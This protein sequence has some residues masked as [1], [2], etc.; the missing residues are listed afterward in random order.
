MAGPLAR[1]DL[2][3]KITSFVD[4]TPTG[5]VGMVLEGEAGI[6]KTTLWE[7]G[8]ARARESNAQ[9][10]VARVAQAEST[11]AFTALG[12]LF[13]GLPT[14]YFEGL[15]TPQREALEIALLYREASEAAHDPRGVG[16][17]CLAVL[18][19]AQLEAPVL[20]AIDD[21]Q[22]LDPSS[23]YTLSFVLHRLRDE[24]VRLLATRRDGQPM[25]AA[26]DLERTMAPGQLHR[27]QVGPLPPVGISAML[28]DRL[29][30]AF[31]Q[32]LGLR[33]HAASGGNPFFA[34]QIAHEILREGAP[35]PGDALPL[36]DDAFTLVRQRVESLPPEAQTVLR[37]CAAASRPSLELVRRA[38]GSSGRAVDVEASLLLCEQAGLLRVRPMRIGF[39]HPLFASGVL[40]A[41]PAE[42]ARAIHLGLAQVVEEPEQR[43]RHLAASSSCPDGEAAAALEEASQ[44]ARGR[45]AAAVAAELALMAM[46]YTPRAQRPEWLRRRVRSAMY[47]FEAGNAPE[48][49][50]VLDGA[51]GDADHGQDRAMLMLLA[52]EISWQDTRRVEDLARAALDEEHADAWVGAGAH[53]M[54][55]WV[56]VYRGDRAAA[57]HHSAA[58]LAAMGDDPDPAVRSDVLTVGALVDFLDG[59]PFEE[60]LAEAV[61]LQE[62]AET[63][64]ATAAV[65]YSPARVVRGLIALWANR[66]AEA[67]QLLG[68]ELQDYEARGRYVARDE[69]LC[70]LANL[71]CRRGEW[72]KAEIYAEECLD[73]GEESGHLRGRGQNI[74]PRAWVAALRGDVTQARSRAEEGLALS[75]ANQDHL[76]TAMNRGV[77][78]F[79]ALSEGDPSTAVGHLLPMV[80]F[81]KDAGWAEPGMLPFVADA[82]EAL[83]LTARADE[84]ASIVADER[85]MGR[86]R[87]A[88]G[89]LA[90]RRR[91]QG[92]LAASA[93]DLAAALP[94]FAEAVAAGHPQPFEH[95]RAVLLK[96]EAE[97]R[98]KRK[99]RARQDL[100]HA[101][102]LFDELGAVVWAERARTELARV[103]GSAAGGDLSPT[104]WRIAELVAGGKTNREVASLLFLS[105][106]TVEANLSRIY[107][108]LGV[109]S[110]SDLVR[111]LLS[112][113]APEP[114]SVVVPLR[115][116]GDTKSGDASGRRGTS[117]G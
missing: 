115:A 1:G 57:T 80:G 51:I 45:G 93:G 72:D 10:A 105:T 35:R 113:P 97:R 29:G 63:V 116:R 74:A 18:R 82:V 76:A 15:P 39:T 60:R 117:K 2:L 69:L 22:W 54:L 79:I 26:L 8:V 14:R 30:E 33:V 98:A 4:A 48:A 40:A 106:K 70:Y 59:G 85:L 3:R 101:V 68:A 32:S 61:A 88:P 96:G 87:S 19:R 36:P 112:H 53:A 11:L 73:I 16:L 56:F 104:E 71:A 107:R 94:L 52:C 75:R 47:A 27:L 64:T 109:R 114:A 58:A 37:V 7:A 34:Q 9:V 49:H 65:V 12:D 43:A 67:G 41:A 46:E 81:L 28:R 111:V 78:G 103:G 5:F 95:A 31:P 17:A 77:L 89:S 83:V 62:A 21:V 90:T 20:L 92:L 23:A 38:C 110:R 25:A 44:L 100:E 99:V 6:G 102:R 13:E 108:K 84:A 55:A 91:C 86:L 66:L 42:D 50:L 24:R